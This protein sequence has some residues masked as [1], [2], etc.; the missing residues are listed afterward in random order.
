[1]FDAAQWEKLSATFL[2]NILHSFTAKK[3]EFILTIRYGKSN[4][5]DDD[6]K[7][8]NTFFSTVY[9]KFCLE[10]FRGFICWTT[11]A[12]KCCVKHSNGTVAAAILVAKDEKTA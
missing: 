1:M 10:M 2:P 6:G 8:D 11:I 12:N 9:M 3:K 7:F 4:I 5:M